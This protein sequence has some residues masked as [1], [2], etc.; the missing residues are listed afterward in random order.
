MVAI[1]HSL[2]LSST[3][4]TGGL[5]LDRTS[6]PPQKEKHAHRKKKELDGIKQRHVSSMK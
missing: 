1:P 5:E 3:V 2:A 6:L 4:W